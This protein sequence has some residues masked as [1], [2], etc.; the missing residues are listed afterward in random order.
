MRS[1]FLVMVPLMTLASTAG[2]ADDKYPVT[3]GE[4]LACTA[5]AVRLCFGSY[6][7]EDRLLGC[8]KT[9]RA[10]LSSGCRVAFDAGLKRRRL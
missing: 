6:P 10:A 1:I 9:N 5:D 8:M 2:A 3:A 7:D 4:K